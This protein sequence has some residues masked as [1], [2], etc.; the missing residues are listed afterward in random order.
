MD[1]AAG[2]S[3]VDHAAAHRCD[4]I[5]A[6]REVIDLEPRAADLRDAVRIAA[7]G[8]G[9]LLLAGVRERAAVV[10]RERFACVEHFDAVDLLPDSLER[11]APDVV[12]PVPAEGMR[13]RHDAA[14]IVDARDGVLGREV[15]RDRLLEEE[16]DDLAITAGDLLAADPANA[17]GDLTHPER[18]LDP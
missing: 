5:V 13:H 2:E 14:L 17:A 16:P 12:Q 1:R 6:A 11:R 9:K 18:S 4:E 7:D 8:T 15:A 10:G 3:S